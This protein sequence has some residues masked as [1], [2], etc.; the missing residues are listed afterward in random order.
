SANNLIL[1]KR[2]IKMKHSE[3]KLLALSHVLMLT[4]LNAVANAEEK[5]K[6]E[7]IKTRD[8]N[9]EYYSVKS[10]Q[11]LGEFQDDLFISGGSGYIENSKID[12]V[13]YKGKWQV[14]QT[15]KVNIPN[16]RSSI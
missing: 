3:K 13:E 2:K 15:D 11:K 6:P 16:S 4:T 14:D 9:S 1:S 10:H 5:K 7:L 8:K 12:G